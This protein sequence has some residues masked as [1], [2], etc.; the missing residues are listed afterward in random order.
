MWL[1]MEEVA[2]A[3]VFEQK[4]L[5]DVLEAEPLEDAA[6]VEYEELGT[7]H[8]DKLQGLLQN[9]KLPKTD[10][11]RI[12]KTMEHYRQWVDTMD[13]L[14]GN[15]DELVEKLV[16]ALN[17]YK[18]HVDLEL[19]FDSPNDFLYRQ[20]GQLKISSSILEE[21]LPRLVDP[22]IIPSL[23][24]QTYSKG[25]KKSFASA[26]FATGLRNPATG[27]G[28]HIRTKDQDFTVGRLVYLR[29]S[30]DETF[31][32]TKTV[33]QK[34][35]LAF[36]AAECKTNLDKTM[37]QEATATSHDLR[38]GLPGSN[39]FLLCEW[40]DM[41]VPSREGTD[42]RRVYI[43]RGKRLA[44]DV[45]AKYATAAGRQSARDEYE[46]RLRDNPIRADRMI[47]FVKD[48]RAIL[49]VSHETEADV[50]SRGY[51]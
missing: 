27:A 13:A 40:L 3:S 33:T 22:R 15:G 7:P 28:L 12:K 42:I 23:A 31:P 10:E 18:L 4:D 50:L 8:Y 25:S 39:Y 16:G 19:V 1:V 26:Y 48:M 2:P 41:P 32:P 9:A 36:I 44:S 38:I 14:R 30:L 47:E 35:F 49:D 45:R 29:S 34:A 11:R 24:G 17:E 21:F 37:W 5:D 51:F 43:F 46:A 6:F 20:N